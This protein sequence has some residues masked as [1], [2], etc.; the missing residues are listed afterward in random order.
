VEQIETPARVYRVF[1]LDPPQSSNDDRAISVTRES[2]VEEG[3]EGRSGRIDLI[4]K[5]GEKIA[6]VV[7]VKTTD[8]DSAATE[9]NIGYRKSISR[10]CPEAQFRLLATCGEKEVY[11]EFKLV[12]WGDI[13]SALRSMA[14]TLC[15]ENSILLAA[16]VL[17]FVGAVEENL[18]A[19]PAKKLQDLMRGSPVQV[20]AAIGNHIEQ[21]LKNDEGTYES[22]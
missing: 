17:A 14:K 22:S 16:M 9:K 10:E 3:H 5:F 19:F 6:I 1:G 21:W 12:T 11:D 8:A 15:G 4:I 7:E 18:L 13:C 2:R 20:T